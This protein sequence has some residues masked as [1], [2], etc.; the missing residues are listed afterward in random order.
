M[1]AL[2][3]AIAVFVAILAAACKPQ[4]G[5]QPKYEAYEKSDFFDNGSAMRPLPPH[6]VARGQADAYDAFHTGINPDGTLVTEFPEPVTPELLARG[7]EQFNIYCSVC[8]GFTGN[9]DGM[10]VQRGFPTPPTFHQARLREAPIGH[11]VHVIQSGYGVMFPYGSRVDAPDRWAIA[12]YI[13]ALQLSENATPVDA[14][15]DERIK[16]EEST[17]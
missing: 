15:A 16:L 11:F 2:S 17:Q 10:I 7:R 12:G 6:T 8:H 4:M 5:V 13:R 9:A 14:P 1:K 3:L